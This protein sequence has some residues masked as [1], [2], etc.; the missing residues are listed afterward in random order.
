MKCLFKKIFCIEGNIGAGKSTLLELL[1]K[2]VPYCKV[3]QEP[4]A[5]WKNIGGYDLLAAFYE[6]PRRWCF[7]FELYSMFT[8]IKKIQD[9]LLDDVEIILVERSIFSNRAFQFISYSLDNLD[10]KEMTILKEIF[11][12]FKAD[13]P[14]LN[15]VIY[16]DVDVEM[17]LQRITKRGRK[18]EKGINYIYLR[19]LEEQ[20]KAIKY[21]CPVKVIDGN[22]DLKKPDSVID[23]ILKFIYTDN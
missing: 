8:I 13:Y 6:D 14:Q 11:T 5:E 12:F 19:K 7:T 1:E 16:L 4:V 18:E 15:G 10:T 17:C 22:Y 21:N 23:E 3:I 2:K 9:A 20:F